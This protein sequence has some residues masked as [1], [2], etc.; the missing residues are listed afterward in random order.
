MLAAGAQNVS[1]G[2]RVLTRWQGQEPPTERTGSDLPGLL[3]SCMTWRASSFPGRRKDP[4][5]CRCL[6]DSAHFICIF[7]GARAGEAGACA[8]YLHAVLTFE[9]LAAVMGHLVADEVGLPVE[10]LGTLVTLVLPFLCV[11]NHV[12]LQAACGRGT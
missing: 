3:P 10:G 12:L 1:L 4:K 6:M 8:C 2:R 11:H 7:G 9:A 5:D